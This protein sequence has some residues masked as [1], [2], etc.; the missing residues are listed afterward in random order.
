MF[1][2]FVRWMLNGSKTASASLAESSPARLD[3]HEIFVP[4]YFDVFI[5]KIDLVTPQ[6]CCHEITFF[7]SLSNKFVQ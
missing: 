1:K 6:F 2:L 3:D 4:T 7:M 5:T